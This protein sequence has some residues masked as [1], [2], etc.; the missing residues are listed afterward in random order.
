[1]STRR[2]QNLTGKA[3]VKIRQKILKN[4]NNRTT[5]LKKKNDIS[6]G[7]AL[8]LPHENKTKMYLLICLF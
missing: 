3:K 8:E 1:M 6:T 2:N 4:E 5:V 7:R